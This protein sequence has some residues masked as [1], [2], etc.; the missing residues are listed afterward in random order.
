M[1]RSRKPNRMN[2]KDYSEDGCYFVTS[3]CKD[4]IH[5]FGKVVNGEMILNEFG[6]IVK[7][8]I[9]WL[10]E[11]YPYL[12]I[13]NWVVMPNH[14]HFL[15][16]IDRGRIGIGTGRDLSVPNR[17]LNQSNSESPNQS[18]S[19]SPENSI[20]NFEKNEI[21]EIKIKSISSLL[22]AF[23]TTSSKHIHLSGNVDFAWHRSFHDHIGR[24][25]DAF[26]NMDRYITNNPKN[27][28]E[29]KF[30]GKS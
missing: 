8:Q 13:H 20:E 14:V 10:E 30:N 11:Q 12:K 24:N 28:D 7:Q 17:A 15:M 22:G 26:R 1:L 25:S 4:N 23:K 5:Y 2:G 19:E 9:L 3:N 16:E 29:D 6:K 18:H 21:Q 27:W